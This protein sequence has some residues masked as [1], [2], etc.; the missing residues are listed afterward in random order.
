MPNPDNGER[1]TGGSS[2]QATRNTDADS[3]AARLELDLAALT[4]AK[5]RITREL[6]DLA[7]EAADVFL[8]EWKY[9]EES[10]Q[11]D[12]SLHERFEV[13]KNVLEL[14]S[15]P[16]KVTIGAFRTPESAKIGKIVLAVRDFI[17]ACELLRG[18]GRMVSNAREKAD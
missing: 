5:Q 9:F 4:D 11:P 7:G 2:P 16:L 8:R 10:V 12:C 1:R 6:T 3:R 17:A 14:T 13:M 15:E 18:D